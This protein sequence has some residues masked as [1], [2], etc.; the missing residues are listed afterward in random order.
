MFVMPAQRVGVGAPHGVRRGK[1]GIPVQLVIVPP[2]F[3]LL[4]DASAHFETQIG[5]DGHI[6]RIEQAMDVTP[7]QES[8]SG[9]MFAAIAVGANMRGFERW[10]SSLARDC[11]M[12]SRAHGTP[13]GRVAA[14]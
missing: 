12:S 5:R 7:K 8:V 13:P 9:L 11:A 14:G 3:K 2:V 10:Q 1:D 6:T 4:L